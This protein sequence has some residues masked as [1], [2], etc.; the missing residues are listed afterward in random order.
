MS[1]YANLPGFLHALVNAKLEKGTVTYAM[2]H[3]IMD[4]LENPTTIE[5]LL[6]NTVR[7]SYADVHSALIDSLRPDLKRPFVFRLTFDMICTNED[8][9]K[10]TDAL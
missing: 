9:T 10:V 6:K 7:S 2:A 8:C 4:S 1:S 3:C 5:R